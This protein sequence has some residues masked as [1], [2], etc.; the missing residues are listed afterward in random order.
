MIYRGLYHFS[1][2]Q[3]KGQSTNPVRYFAAPENQD[4]GVVKRQRKP[5]VKLIIVPFPDK[6]RSSDLFF[7]QASAQRPLTTI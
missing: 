1:V 7:F 4:L 5:Q 3:Q 2:A 6:Q